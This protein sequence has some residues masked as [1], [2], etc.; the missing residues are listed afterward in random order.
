MDEKL[1][2]I[3]L[4]T[5]FSCNCSLDALRY[6]GE[7]MEGDKVYRQF[8]SPSPHNVIKLNEI[9][10]NFEDSSN[11]PYFN[12]HVIVRQSETEEAVAALVV[13]MHDA[14]KR[15]MIAS[16]RTFEAKV[17]E[18]YMT[19]DKAKELIAEEIG[20]TKSNGAVLVEM[21]GF[22]DKVLGKAFSDGLNFSKSVEDGEA[23][24]KA[25]FDKNVTKDLVKAFVRAMPVIK[26]EGDYLKFE[27]GKAAD[28]AGRMVALKFGS[29]ACMRFSEEMRRRTEKNG[30]EEKKAD[31]EA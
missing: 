9:W 29:D 19:A 22:A 2:K 18:M 4:R 23:K 15:L 12:A 25:F 17:S 6:S 27:N 7:V 21:D 13:K 5:G 1:M 14:L 28:E 3:G 16:V 11:T 20:E 30:K 10:I 31:A 8:D 24:W 26:S